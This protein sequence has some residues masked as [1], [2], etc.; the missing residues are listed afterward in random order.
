MLKE[1]PKKKKKQVDYYH[2]SPWQYFWR[3]QKEGWRRAI[4][5]G[6]MYFFMSLIMLALQAIDI[7]WLQIALGIVCIAGGIFFNAHL[8]FH[9]GSAHYDFFLT[10]EVYRRR[11]KEEGYVNA[12]DH[13]LEKEYR[14]WKGFFI[15]FLMSIPVIILSILAG[16]FDGKA[17]EGDV[18]WVYA[19]LAGCAVVPITWLRNYVPSMANL[20]YYWTA[21]T[22]LVPIVV[23][24]VFYILGA[25]HNRRKRAEKEERERAVKAA[26][27]A[28]REARLHHEQTEAQRQKTLQS[29]KKK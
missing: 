27:E 18:L 8:V 3:L 4:T 21:L 28:A 11:E 23:S 9:F 17:G 2:P 13:H 10:G 14:P 6:L 15:G 12:P 29:K 5:P 16:T 19:M 24:G 1:A 20:S 7:V 22:I 25:W 26:A